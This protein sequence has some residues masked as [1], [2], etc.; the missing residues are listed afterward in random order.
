MCSLCCEKETQMSKAEIILILV[1]SFFG[2]AILSGLAASAIYFLIQ[3]Y[4]L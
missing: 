2:M 3:K 1:G 4:D